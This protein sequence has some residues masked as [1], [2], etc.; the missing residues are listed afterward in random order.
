MAGKICDNG[1]D[2]G[3]SR[4]RVHDADRSRSVGSDLDVDIVGFRDRGYE[5]ASVGIEPTR[6]DDDRLLIKILY[7]GCANAVANCSNPVLDA[8]SFLEAVND[9]R[10]CLGERARGIHKAKRVAL[11]PAKLI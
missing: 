10:K 11:G 2:G 4:V 8:R 6:Q 9:L 1:G 3:I 5:M 7:S